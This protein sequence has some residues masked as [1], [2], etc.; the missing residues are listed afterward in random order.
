[1]IDLKIGTNKKVGL[2][3]G[4]PV[5]GVLALVGSV[6]E[7][8]NS[9]GDIVRI[10]EGGASVGVPI[11]IKG[12]NITQPI[13]GSGLDI[14]VTNSYSEDIEA[15]KV[16]GVISGNALLASNQWSFDSDTLRH[17]ILK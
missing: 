17:L 6:S 8:K 14:G 16:S 2:S 11:K 12:M 1:M 5:Y 15:G 13:S 4:I 7:Q 10:Y 9:N 3:G